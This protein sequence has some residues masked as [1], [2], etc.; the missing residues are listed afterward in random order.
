MPSLDESYPDL[1]AA[2]A[3]P[4]Q[5]PS[6]ASDTGHGWEAVVR[7]VLARRP[8]GRRADRVMDVLAE[9]G[10]VEPAVLADASPAEVRD[11]LEHAGIA[12]PP[13]QAAILQRLARWFVDAFPDAGAGH[14][15]P[16]SLLRDGL[17]AI[18]GV[19]PGTADAVLL[20]LGRA[21][22]PVDPGIYRILVRHGWCDITADYDEASETLARPARG[23]VAELGQVHRELSVVARRF[24]GVRV[25]KCDRC[26]LRELLPEA[27]PIDP[28]E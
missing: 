26:P 18:N 19:G 6:A 14:G 8:A 12:I 22:L 24:C 16:T 20:A 2:L 21:C 17:L 3:A 15:P 13:R 9:A 7:A 25:P 10:W 5:S 23:D 11:A 28:R 4:G 1:V 27:G